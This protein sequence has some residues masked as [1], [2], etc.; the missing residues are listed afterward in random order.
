[1]VVERT[2]NLPAGR[3]TA[4]VKLSPVSRTGKVA[5]PV[6]IPVE[7]DIL[8]DVQPDAPVIAFGCC[9]VGDNAEGH[10]ILTSLSGRSFRVTK[11]NTDLPDSMELV[12]DNPDG[13]AQSFTV[14][15]RVTAVG[16]RTGTLRF[17]G[18]DA[19]G[20]PFEAVIEVRWF[21]TNTL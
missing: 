6:H 16:D 1:L 3:Y 10:V 14:R 7:F 8:G 17:S 5:P 13:P 9:K 19:D 2:P 4:E 11:Q 21:G 12:P 20:K 18:Q 15:L